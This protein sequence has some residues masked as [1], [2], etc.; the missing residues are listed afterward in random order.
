MTLVDKDRPS[1]EWIAALKRTLPC[2]TEIARVLDRKLRRRAGPPYSPV[3]LD[4]LCEGARALIRSQ[5]GDEFEILSAGWLSGGAS[6]LQM[7]F[8][9]RWAQPGVGR[10]ETPMVLRMEPSESIVETSRLREFQLIKAA[11]FAVPVPPVFWLDQH[12]DF[13]PYPAIIYGFADGVTKPSGSVSNVTGLGIN[14]GAGLRPVIGEQF[15]D[16]LVKIHK[17]DWAKAD[18]SGFDV[19][20]LGTQAVEWQINWWAR[21]WAEDSHE[22]VPLVRYAERWLRAKMPAVDRVSVIHGDYRAG[23]F[24][25]T[26]EDNRITAWLDWEMG[27]LGDRHKDIAY[28]C[29]RSSG[30]FSEDGKTFLVNG[31]MSEDEFYQAYERSSG[32]PVDL[33]R[34]RYYHVLNAYELAVL[35]LATGY[36]AVKGGKTHQDVVLSWLS[37]IGYPIL[38]ELRVALEGAA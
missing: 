18:M 12:G 35:I 14:F 10:T 8:I 33:A 7:R 11:E 5:I 6:K 32:E 28:A 24:L 13:L 4:T 20:Q 21:I 19:P 34:V 36:R 37:G 16:H 3:S 2:E 38:E 17:I 29:K 26:E 9:L 23:N 15:V 25:Y 22:D 27:H 30:H 31:L 1:E